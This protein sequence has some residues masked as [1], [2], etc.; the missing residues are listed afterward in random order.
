[1]RRD[2]AHMREVRAPIEH[3]NALTTLRFFAAFHVLLFHYQSMFFYNTFRTPTPDAIWLGF[4]SVTFFFVLSG[5][6]LA[7]NYSAVKFDAATLRLYACAR[8]SRIYPVYLLS[9]LIAMPFLFRQIGGQPDWIHPLWI[10]SIILAPLGLHAWVPGAACALNCPSWSISTEFFFYLMFPLLM[11][12]ALRRPGMFASATVVFWLLTTLFY[13]WLWQKTGD[14]Q[15]V[16]RTAEEQSRAAI[17]SAQLI[18]YFPIGRLPEFMAGIAAYVFWSAN[19][20]RIS[21]STALSLF[22]AMAT[23]ILFF[24]RDIPEIVLHNGATVGAWVA[25]IVAAASMRGGVLT[26]PIAVSLGQASF[27]LYL[28]HG[29]VA[30]AVFAVDTMFFGRVLREW[31][32]STATLTTILSIALS[33][34]VFATFEEPCRRALRRRFSE[35]LRKQ[36][37]HAERPTPT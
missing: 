23:I 22:A 2:I 1:M 35:H 6:I 18:K 15:S 24:H 26:H 30:L 17:L 21:A 10:A 9:L 29:P 32:W 33:S 5:F 12:I 28:L 19:R 4:T 31:P 11:P 20:Q 3:L 7:H 13:I 16:I 27:S 34:I 14:G 36:E 25:L 8:L 37:S